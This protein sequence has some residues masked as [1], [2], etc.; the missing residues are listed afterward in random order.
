VDRNKVIEGLVAVSI[1][2]LRAGFNNW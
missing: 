1:P 2:R